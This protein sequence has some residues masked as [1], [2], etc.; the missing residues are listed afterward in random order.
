MNRG[1]I[2]LTIDEAEYLLDQIPPPSVDDTDLVKKLRKRFQDL[3][4]ELRKGA[5]GT[6][7]E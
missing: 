4:E 5:E 1:P 7:V 3:L 6:R 2:V